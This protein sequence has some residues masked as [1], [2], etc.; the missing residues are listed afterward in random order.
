[1]PVVDQRLATPWSR[2]LAATLFAH[3]LAG[4]GV[5]D[6]AWLCGHVP[7][8][9][10]LGAW[11]QRE[12]GPL[13]SASGPWGIG[14]LAGGLAVCAGDGGGDQV[15]VAV[16]EAAEVGAQVDGDV[17]VA[18]AGGDAEHCLLGAGAGE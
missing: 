2:V 7:G 6:P 14:G 15:Y 3:D 8:G 5:R 4:F 13:V 18:E 11:G 9:R 12:G 1:M 17:V 10:G 16:V